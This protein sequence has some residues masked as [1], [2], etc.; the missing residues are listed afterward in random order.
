MR[1]T[2]K[3]LAVASLLGAFASANYAA[4]ISGTVK[5]PEGQPSEGAFVQAQ[6]TKTRMTFIV[7]TD[8]QGRYRIEN[9][10]AGGY[11]VQARATGFRADAQSGV[12][13]TADQNAA[14][15]FA[16]QKTAEITPLLRRQRQVVPAVLRLPR[17]PN[18]HGLSPSRCRRLAGSRSVHARCHALQPGLAL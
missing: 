16:L 3:L 15:D 8:A 7:L 5:S 9:L 12:S 17:I 2:Q 18:A 4:T 6:N 13:L 10:P 11:T 1:T 14:Y